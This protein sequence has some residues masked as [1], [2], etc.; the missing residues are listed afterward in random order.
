MSRGRIRAGEDS[1]PGQ[2]PNL[3]RQPHTEAHNPDGNTEIGTPGN[4][5]LPVENVLARKIRL[6]SI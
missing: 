2:N 4:E 3:I 1:D 6:G 5:P